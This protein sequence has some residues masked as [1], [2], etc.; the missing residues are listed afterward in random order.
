MLKRY[1]DYYSNGINMEDM[2]GETITKI[3]EKVDEIYFT[4]ASGHTVRMY[5]SQ[6]CCEDV[7]IEDICGDLEDLVG[8]PLVMARE[9]TSEVPEDY[10]E[11]IESATW[12]FYRMGTNK[13]DVTIRWFGQSNG[14]YSET[15]D[16][17]VMV[18]TPKDEM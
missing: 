13:G 4:L 6:D 17:E 7:T 5:H 3:W 12:T 10:N 1:Y 11:Y 16:L 15:A 14:Y 9:S 2:L 8:S 18:K